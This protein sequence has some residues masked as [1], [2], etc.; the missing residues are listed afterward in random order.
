M[1]SV[2]C[3]YLQDWIPKLLRADYSKIAV[4]FAPGESFSERASLPNPQLD[5]W[6]L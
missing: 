3:P 2:S 6:V 1:P 5:S 4:L